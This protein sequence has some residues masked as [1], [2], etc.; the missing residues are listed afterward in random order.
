MGNIEPNPSPVQ[1]SPTHLNFSKGTGDSER[2]EEKMLLFLPAKGV[3]LQDA[4]SQSPI[5][6]I[7]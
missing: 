6:R 5:T 4:I 7:Q 3:K 2:L 1:T